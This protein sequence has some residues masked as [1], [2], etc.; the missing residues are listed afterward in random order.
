MELLQSGGVSLNVDIL[1]FLIEIFGCIFAQLLVLNRAVDGWVT[2]GYKPGICSHTEESPSPWLV[3]D[4]QGNYGIS[5]VRIT[6]RGDCCS[7]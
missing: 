1:I 4:L 5:Y 2:T 6:N 3:V 7:K